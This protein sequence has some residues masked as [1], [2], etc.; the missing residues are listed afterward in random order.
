MYYSHFY[1]CISIYVNLFTVHITSVASLTV[2]NMP[3]RELLAGDRN[4]EFF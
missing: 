4:K 2:V 3:T 1:F